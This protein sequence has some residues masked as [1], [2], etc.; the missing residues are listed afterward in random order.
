MVCLPRN[1]MRGHI[2]NSFHQKREPGLQQSRSATRRPFGERGRTQVREAGGSVDEVPAGMIFAGGRFSG[3]YPPADE[4][5]L[6]LLHHGILEL[7]KRQ[8]RAPRVSAG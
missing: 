6:H 2:A 8:S 1:C 3:E 7:H 5:N 4:P